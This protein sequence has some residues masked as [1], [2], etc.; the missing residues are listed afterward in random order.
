VKR[1]AFLAGLL[2]AAAV[3]TVEAQ[4][5]TAPKVY[6]LAIVDPSSSAAEISEKSVLRGSGLPNRPIRATFEEFRRLG[7]VE[8]QN[9]MI[10][11]FTREGRS[12]LY[13]ELA[14]DSVRSNPD[15]IFA[16]GTQTVI[17]L[18]A[19]TTTIPIVGWV[20]DPVALG[21]VNSVARPG[22]NITGI[23]ATLD[24]SIWGKRVEL[25]RE[26]VSNLSKVGFLDS[27]Y[28]WNSPYGAIVREAAGR[29]GIS[30][31]GPPLD[32]PFAAAEYRRV[33][34]AMTQEGI[35][36]L[37]VGDQQ[38]NYTNRQLIIELAEQNR[39]PAIYPYREYAELGGLMA[40]SFDFVDL[41]RH[42]VH[43]IDSILKGAK[44]GEIPFYQSTG[45]ALTINL[46]TAKTLGT[47]PSF[48]ALADDVVE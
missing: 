36:A 34:T 13:P 8:G 47:A 12:D 39:L 35:E 30:L 27:R 42:A 21:I 40:Y 17:T 16:I 32:A 45:L 15:V 10:E 38:D 18:K 25:L 7:Y 24:L 6:R 11:R 14:R 3:E 2:S 22:G 46:K 41:A 5:G 44:P 29:I 9:L 1:R 23:T 43:Q 19:A 28:G 33:L 20:A 26:A 31:A 48:L 4:Q 37:I